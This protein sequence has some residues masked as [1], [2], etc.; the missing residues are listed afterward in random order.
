MTAKKKITLSA[1]VYFLVV[2]L[3]TTIYKIA[4]SYLVFRLNRMLNLVPFRTWKSLF[5]RGF[6][7]N[8]D[9]LVK[10]LLSALIFV[11]LAIY[12][13]IKYKNYEDSKSAKTMLFIVALAFP[14]LNII[15]KTGV[16][17]I[18]MVIFR[19]A[20]TFLSYFVTSK[21][22]SKTSERNNQFEV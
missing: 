2:F 17:D 12:F 10:F 5:Q 20:L 21:I 15:L 11:P 7:I 13:A 14:L 16:F 19:I 8:T 22:V 9:I 3:S 18:D 6:N 4:H 1:I